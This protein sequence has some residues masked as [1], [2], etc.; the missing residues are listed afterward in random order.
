MKRNT[1]APTSKRSPLGFLIAPLLQ[2][3]TDAAGVFKRYF[4]GTGLG[5]RLYKAIRFGSLVDGRVATSKLVAPTERGGAWTHEPPPNA[6]PFARRSARRML[7]LALM[8]L[9]RMDPDSGV[10]SG[11]KLWQGHDARRLGFSLNRDQWNKLGGTREV[12]R[13]LRIFDRAEVFGRNQPNA[14]KVPEHMKG[15]PHADGRSWAYNVLRTIR[16]FGMPQ[17]IRDTLRR[18]RGQKVPKPSARKAPAVPSEL[19][20]VASAA[21]ALA[22]FMA[23]RPPPLR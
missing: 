14:D 22:W 1:P 10:A 23:S 7:A 3:R 4:E 15:A 9:E 12:Q 11:R 20:H 6:R 19:A 16:G 18:W 17:V 5:G 13:Y 21:D 8:I 2:N